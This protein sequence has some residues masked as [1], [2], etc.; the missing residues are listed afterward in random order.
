LAILTFEKGG[1]KRKK[2]PPKKALKKSREEK[3]GKKQKLFVLK[4][5]C[6]FGGFCKRL[7]LSG[8]PRVARHYP[9]HKKHHQQAR[10]IQ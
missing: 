9:E 1:E 10:Q 8:L 3:R 4:E 2:F 7:I 5:T 6:L